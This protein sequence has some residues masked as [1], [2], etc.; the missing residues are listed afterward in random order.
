M[1]PQKAAWAIAHKLLRLIW[2][3]LRYG[4]EYQEYG[5]LLQD[6]QAVKRQR[7]RLTAALRKLGYAVTLTP[8][9]VPGQT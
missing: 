7:I 1:G 9:P 2:K 6:P 5:T 3:I 4:T 8:L